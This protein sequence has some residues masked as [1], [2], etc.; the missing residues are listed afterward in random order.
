MV[1][2][3]AQK[4]DLDSIQNVIET[5]FSD[6]IVLFNASNIISL[7]RSDYASHILFR[8]PMAIKRFC[9]RSFISIAF[10]SNLSVSSLTRN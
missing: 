3:F 2:R 5:A 7:I 1:I 9:G 6:D 10:I 4:T 8:S